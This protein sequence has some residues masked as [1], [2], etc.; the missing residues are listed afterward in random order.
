MQCL[1]EMVCLVRLLLP[2]FWSS[3]LYFSFIVMGYFFFLSEALITSPSV[4]FF[5]PFLLDKKVITLPFFTRNKWVFFVTC[6][7]LC[8]SF[9]FI[10]E[11]FFFFSNKI[12]SLKPI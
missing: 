7:H 12:V 1:E 3:Q 4:F 2:L 5:K 10:L 6:N 9:F 11:V 8:L